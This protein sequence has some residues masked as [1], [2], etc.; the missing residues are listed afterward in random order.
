MTIK[1]IIGLD[2]TGSMGGALIKACEVIGA[3]F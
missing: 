1:T 3:A 2:A